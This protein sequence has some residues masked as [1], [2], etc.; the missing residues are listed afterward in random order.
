VTSR[1]ALVR[2]RRHSINYDAKAFAPSSLTAKERDTLRGDVV[3]RKRNFYVVLISQG[4]SEVRFL[5]Q[6]SSR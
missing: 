6:A 1:I 3:M 5:D 4:T 2:R